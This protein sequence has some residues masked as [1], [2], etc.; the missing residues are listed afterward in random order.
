[1]SDQ[2][3]DGD[4]VKPTSEEEVN[5]SYNEQAKSNPIKGINLATTEDLE[6]E[7][8]TNIVEKFTEQENNKPDFSEAEFLMQAENE[9]Q[10]LNERNK[11]EPEIL[12]SFVTE[13]DINNGT[14]ESDEKNEEEKLENQISKSIENL[15]ETKNENNQTTLPE[16]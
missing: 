4:T 9:N 7:S 6:K 5:E 10:V 16:T 12:N 13:K 14:K 11:I 15:I 2:N 1:M 8:H 3:N